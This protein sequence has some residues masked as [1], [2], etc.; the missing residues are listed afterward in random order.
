MPDGQTLPDFNTLWNFSQPAET[1]KKFRELLPLAESANE[2]SYLAQLLTQIARSQGLQGQF[3]SAHAT[4]DRVESMLTDEL[5][6]ARV[7][8][9]LERGRVFNSSDQPQ[10]SLPIFL[11]AFELA[12]AEKFAR[13]AIDAAHMIAIAEPDPEKQ[14]EWNLRGIEMAQAD[15]SQHGW[16]WSLYNN[17]AESYAMLA[18]YQTSMDYVRKLLA[19]QKERGEPD[20]FTLKDEAKFLRMLGKP[21]EALTV[22]EPLLSEYEN[23]GWVQE[24]IAESLHALGRNS[25]AL[26]YFESAWS[27][28]SQSEWCMKKEPAKLARLKRMA[29]VEGHS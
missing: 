21:E 20:V 14:I 8:C 7:R 19:F 22:L 26:P 4:L 2:P 25:E 27:L 24:E 28:L 15:E 9:W 29:R 3:D 13:C 18:E 16:L 1:E 10:K 5:K 11:Q 17:I 6:L 12:L 23:N